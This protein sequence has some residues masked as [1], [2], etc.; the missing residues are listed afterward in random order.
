ME[1]YSR[2]ST[3]VLRNV[4]T[5]W[6]NWIINDHYINIEYNERETTMKSNSKEL[7]S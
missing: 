1:Q 4:F 3:F 6:I 5:D 2:Q 7:S